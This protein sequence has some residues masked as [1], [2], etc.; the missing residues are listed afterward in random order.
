MTYYRISPKCLY[1]N[2]SIVSKTWKTKI[3]KWAHKTMQFLG[4][5]QTSKT[6]SKTIYVIVCIKIIQFKILLGSYPQTQQTNPSKTTS[7]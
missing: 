1:F 2:Y 7:K 4:G 6:L 5:V 3:G